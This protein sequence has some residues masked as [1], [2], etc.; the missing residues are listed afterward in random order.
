MTVYF[1]TVLVSFCFEL[2]SVFLAMSVVKAILVICFLCDGFS[3]NWLNADRSQNC[4]KIDRSIPSIFQLHV[5]VRKYCNIG[6]T[7]QVPPQLKFKNILLLLLLCGDVASDPGPTNFG[8]VNCRSIRNK[9]PLLQELIKCSDL[10]ILGLVETHIRPNDTDG[11]LNYLTPTDYNFIQKPRCTGLGGGVGFLC[12]KTFSPRIVSLP[13]FRSFE[14]IIR[15]FKSDYNSFVAACVYCP[16]GSCT[17]Q[18]L[19]D[20]LSSTG[21]RFII[22]GDINVHL[23]IECGDRCRL[24][25]I[26]QCCGLVQSVS[27]PTHLLGHTVFISPCDSDF[28]HN[29]SVGD[30]ISDHAAIKC[31]LDFSHPSI[32]IDIWVSYH[33][34][35]IDQFR[36][37][38]KNIP[39]V[40]SPEGTAAELYDQYITGVTQVL[41]KHAPIISHKA[42]QQS[43]EWL[44]DSYHMAR[45]LRRQFEGRWRKHKL[46]LN[47]SRLRMQIAWCNRLANKDKGSYYANLITANSGDPKK[48]WQSLRKVLHRT[49]ETVLPAHSSD[50]SL[51]DMFASFFSNKISKIMG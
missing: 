48:L 4:E 34:I 5:L 50:K 28:V 46:E 41:D 23:D 25:N 49:S 35:D 12:R 47:R 51:A 2:G 30:F 11:L 22:C 20:F 37:D 6:N 38:L 44:S 42:K 29:V 39:F 36:N 13:V 43:H 1:C 31:Q 16:P 21:S 3:C 18:F 32:S 9:G 19:E 26:L 10:D 24:N 17:T 8:F 27:V 40:R 45:A 33:R 7:K 15:S 14:I